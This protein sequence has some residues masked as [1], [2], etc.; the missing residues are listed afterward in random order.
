M[1]FKITRQFIHNRLFSYLVIVFIVLFSLYL[2]Q[3][4]SQNFLINEYGLLL[5]QIGLL[6]SIR[7]VGAVFLNLI[8]GRLRYPVGFIIAQISVG[9][10]SVFIWLGSGFPWYLI[11]YFLLGGY[12]TAR[13]LANAQATTFVSPVRIGAVYGAVETVIASTTIL[14]PPIAGVLYSYDPASI[15]RVSFLLIILSVIITILFSSVRLIRTKRPGIG[16]SG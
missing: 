1:R 13:S 14:A 15:Y 12:Q 6:I 11:G 3:P 10:F 8:A 2:P 7:S 5:S 9:L 4:L 16:E